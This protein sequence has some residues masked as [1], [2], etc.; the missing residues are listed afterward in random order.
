[1]KAPEYRIDNQAFITELRSTVSNYF[2]ENKINEHGSMQI[3]LKTLFATMLYFIPYVLML[4]GVIQ[5]IGIVLLFWV[6]MGL[7]NSA[8]GVS[9][10][11]DANHGSFS[12]YEWINKLF[13][14]SLYLLGGFPENWRY[15]H[16]TLHHGYTN[17]EGHDEDIGHGGILR[18]SPHKPLQAIHKYQYIY[19]WFLYGLMTFSWVTVKDF[20]RIMRYKKAD[21]FLS[22]GTTFTSLL[23]KLIISKVIYYAVFLV[24]PIIL[25]PVAWYWVLLGFFMMHFTSGFILSAIFQTAHVVPSSDFPLPDGENKLDTNWAINQLNTTSDFAPKSKVFSWFIGGLNFQVVHHLFP[26]ISHVHYKNLSLIV[27]EKAEKY[28]LP[29]HVNRTF[30]GA[31]YQH[32]LMLKSLGRA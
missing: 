18:F 30:I 1:M 5:S 16:N 9:T 15:Q 21:D 8:I 13:S 4:T 19:A 28:N 6:L 31:M 14:N 11:H 24:L 26:N 7:G 10:M 20:I 3:I 25:V 12:K 29:Y 17:I 22:K 27:R 23:W 32:L 2:K